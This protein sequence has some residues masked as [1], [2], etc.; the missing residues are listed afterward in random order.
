MNF[1]SLICLSLS[2]ITF[3]Y[4]ICYGALEYR[5]IPRLVGI[6]S[7]DSRDKL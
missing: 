3:V 2:E 5:K 6:A 4:T 1:K 7:E